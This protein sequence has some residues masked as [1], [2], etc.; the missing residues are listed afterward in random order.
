MLKSRTSLRTSQT[1]TCLCKPSPS[2]TSTLL[3]CRSRP[4]VTSTTTACLPLRWILRNS[5]LRRPSTSTSRGRRT[6]LLIACLARRTWDPRLDSD[7]GTIMRLYITDLGSSLHLLLFIGFLS[8]LTRLWFLIG[9]SF[10]PLVFRI[11]I[12]DLSDL[13]TIST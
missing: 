1:T 8:L 5:T 6:R 10:I 4:E 9:L 11:C 12:T 7:R 3:S 13:I 2:P